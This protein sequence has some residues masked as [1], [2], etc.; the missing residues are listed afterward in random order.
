MACEIK[1][2]FSK[3]INNLNRECSF[4]HW[5]S[6]ANIPTTFQCPIYKAADQGL[7]K[8]HQR[9]FQ[10]FFDSF[11]FSP[12]EDC[13]DPLTYNILKER[14]LMN[15]VYKGE[16][17]FSD[18]SIFFKLTFPHFFQSCHGYIWR[19]PDYAIKSSLGFNVSK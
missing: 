8:S 15:T 1:I 9:C 17:W 4:K 10:R 5:Y 2:I 18:C 3:R 12:L 6:S 16:L 7:R 11:T 13:L 19:L 14:V